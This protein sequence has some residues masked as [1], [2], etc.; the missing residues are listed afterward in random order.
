MFLDLVLLLW[1]WEGIRVVSPLG[2]KGLGF[3]RLWPGQ[4]LTLANR[5][6]SSKPDH[7][8]DVSYRINH[9]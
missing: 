9:I 2:L 1:A 7:I 5:L 3:E 8:A 4:L 6:C